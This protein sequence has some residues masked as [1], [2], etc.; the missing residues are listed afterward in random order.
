MI[1]NKL[2]FDA[3]NFLINELIMIFLIFLLLIPYRF[4][5]F[6]Y[7]QYHISFRVMDKWRMWNFHMLIDSI[8]HNVF[9]KV[10]NRV[11]WIYC[12]VILIIYSQTINFFLLWYLRFY[13]FQYKWCIEINDLHKERYKINLRSFEE[14]LYTIIFKW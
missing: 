6:M 10:L 4:Q 11:K 1:S 7:I 9:H 2:C 8:T 13:Y 14:C 3:F 5:I 12:I